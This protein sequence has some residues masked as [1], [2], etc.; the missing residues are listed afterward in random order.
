MTIVHRRAALG[1]SIKYWVQPAIENRIAEGS[2]RA[3]FNTRV[4]EI[5]PD[6]VAVEGPD[7]RRREAADAVLLMTG[8]RSDTRLVAM[9]GAEINAAAGA[10]VHD[11]AT[12]ETA[13]PNLFLMRRGR[14][15]RQKATASSSSTAAFTRR[16]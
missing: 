2:V 13:V 14:S 9:A 16:S 11:P 15:G 6:G 5:T 4:V 8:Y 3:W 1:E 7:G 10:P 12:F